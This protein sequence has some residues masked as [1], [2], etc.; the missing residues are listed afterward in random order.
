MV[1]DTNS[2][3][4]TTTDEYGS[5]YF[6]NAPLNEEV[7]LSF[8]LD[9]YLT[10]LVNPVAV[11]L[12]E[13]S[14]NK[15]L[16]P[17]NN[18]GYLVISQVGGPVTILS[19]PATDEMHLTGEYNFVFFTEGYSVLTLSSF[20]ESM[21]GTVSFPSGVEVIVKD[22]TGTITK[23]NEDIIEIGYQII[24]RHLDTGLTRTYTIIETP[25]AP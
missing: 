7:N 24:L 23:E 21:T 14:F 8:S 17:S 4:E 2:L 3:G 15:S 5:Y 10:S 19:A 22:S 11:T 25:V 6:E 1:S 16:I 13:Q 12:G 9:Y 20:L 18:A